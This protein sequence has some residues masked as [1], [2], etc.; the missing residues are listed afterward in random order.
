MSFPILIYLLLI[1]FQSVLIFSNDSIEINLP[2]FVGALITPFIILSRKYVLPKS[3]KYLLIL[4]FWFA[5][6]NF[7][8]L[9]LDKTIFSIFQLLTATIPAISFYLYYDKKLFKRFIKIL[10][11]QLLFFIPL[12]LRDYGLFN[13]E[14]LDII[15]QEIS[16]ST[17][18]EYFEI[19]RS[20]ASFNESSYFG[21][22]LTVV[23]FMFEYLKV[24]FFWRILIL[25]EI[26][27]TFSF[28]C[29]ILIFLVYIYKFFRETNV[30]DII[31]TI[32]LSFIFFLFVNYI[33]SNK[34]SFIINERVI[35]SY[36]ALVYGKLT[37]SEGARINS[38][39]IAFNF[40]FE[41][42]NN[43]F[44]GEGFATNRDW[45]KNRFGHEKLNQFG[46][47]H[48]FNTFSAVIFHG[49]IVALILYLFFLFSLFKNIKIKYDFLLIFIYVH[50]VYSG[51]Q[52]Y[53]LWMFI[54][55]FNNI[56]R[57]N[58][59]LSTKNE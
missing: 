39:P 52:S 8:K 6:I 25:L 13:F 36:D 54:F 32:T 12:I 9:G 49:G 31:K 11:F 19:N 27:T 21:I 48:I 44:F 22:Y 3:F 29:F 1:P 7:I 46:E 20:R 26:L 33:T 16:Y 35:T 14:I 17:R 24:N 56:I 30:K 37:G 4:I 40:A 59:Y 45:L 58:L 57:P 41:S 5:T 10:K 15:F 53:Y 18:S 38:L 23:Y 2:T 50:F 42:Y 51:L 55:L 28:G 34:L 47:G 43:F